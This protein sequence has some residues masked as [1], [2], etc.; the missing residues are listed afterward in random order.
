MLTN[1]DIA[2]GLHSNTL[3]QIIVGRIDSKIDL[4]SLFFSAS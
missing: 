2:I 1:H 4:V 3:I